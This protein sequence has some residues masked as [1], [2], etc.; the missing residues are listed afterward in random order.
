MLMRISLTK[1]EVIATTALISLGR[2]IQ[3]IR[4]LKKLKNVATASSF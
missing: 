4:R 3:M 2:M 1:K